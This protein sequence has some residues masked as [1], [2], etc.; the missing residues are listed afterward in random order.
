[1]GEASNAVEA[2][3]RVGTLQPDVLL[4]DIAMPEISGLDVARHLPPARPLI[5]FQT[6]HDEHAVAAFEQEA[7]DYLLKPV[8]R[9]R[10]A[11][12]LERARKRLACRAGAPTRDA[13]GRVER[14]ALPASAPV[15]APAR[16]RRAPATAC[17][18]SVRSRSSPPTRGLRARDHTSGDV[19]DGLH[20]RGSRRA[21]GRGV[22]ARQPRRSR[23]HRLDRAH[24]QRRRRFR[25]ADVAGQA[26]V[27]VSRRRAAA[28][29][30]AH[31]A[32]TLDRSP[33]P[34]PVRARPPRILGTGGYAHVET[35]RCRP[36]PDR[37]GDHSDVGLERVQRGG[38]RDRNGGSGAEL[39]PSARSS[40]SS[41][42]TSGSQPWSRARSCC[43][44]PRP[45]H[46]TRCRPSAS[47][48]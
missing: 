23:Q 14:A 39:F 5:V 42:W 15:R 9:D 2:L 26:V 12:A 1:M 3:D 11:Q 43:C 31:R 45:S 21:A 38:A 24:G 30:R 8:T 6:A 4:L 18:P 40:S 13:I 25:H 47:S 46:R 44:P 32:L 7:I 41:G 20:A 36:H 35:N 22:R 33:G 34:R 16:A 29:R 10:L 28:V 37:D 19:S 48:R 27:H 17:C